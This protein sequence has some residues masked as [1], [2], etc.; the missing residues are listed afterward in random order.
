MIL[1][2]WHS[3]Y[4]ISLS[5][6]RYM[7]QSS[8]SPF[9]LKFSL[10]LISLALIALALYLGKA[11][12]VPLFFAI[13]LA[14]LLA[15][16]TDFLQRKGLNKV[17]TI[18]LTLILAFSI[19]GAIIYFLSSQVGNF[20]EDIPTLQKR[21]NEL[22]ASVQKWIQEHLNITIRKQNQYI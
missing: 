2:K 10:T 12:L 3:I 16:V 5:S 8:E 6:R 22:A 13:L 20:I 11:I 1:H 17:V 7:D 21:L 19:M 14:I 18:L 9:Y 15:R 4:P